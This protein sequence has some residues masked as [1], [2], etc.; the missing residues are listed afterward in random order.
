MPYQTVRRP[1]AGVVAQLVAWLLNTQGALALN[2]GITWAW[3]DTPIILA[4][5]KKRQKDQEFK[6][7]FCYIVSE[8]GRRGV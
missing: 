1:G 6:V 4:S 7:V 3:W 5:R 8:A 2:T